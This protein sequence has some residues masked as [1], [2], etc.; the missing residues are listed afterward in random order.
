[1]STLNGVHKVF[2]LVAFRLYEV[3]K[4]EKTH[5]Y[6]VHTYSNWYI[7]SLQRLVD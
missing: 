5:T 4:E 6:S 7:R 1:M 3:R 2:A